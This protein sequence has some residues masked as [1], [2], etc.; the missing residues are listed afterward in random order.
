MGVRDYLSLSDTQRVTKCVMCQRMCE[1]GAE[2]QLLREDSLVFV[3]VNVHLTVI[4]MQEEAPHIQ[5]AH[6]YR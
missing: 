4:F 6:I 3:C 5:T 2:K 1:G